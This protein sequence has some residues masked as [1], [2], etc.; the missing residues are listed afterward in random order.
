[1]GRKPR[2]KAKRKIWFRNNKG[3][4]PAVAVPRWWIGDADEVEVEVYPEFILIVHPDYNINEVKKRLGL[5]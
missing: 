3:T 2:L 1:M 5:V 4:S